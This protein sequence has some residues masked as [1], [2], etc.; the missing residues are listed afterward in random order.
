MR[1][2]PG[3]QCCRRRALHYFGGCF[4]YQKTHCKIK[5]EGWIGLEEILPEIQ[6]L[7]PKANFPSAPRRDARGG[8]MFGAEVK[9]CN[10]KE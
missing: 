2:V 6:N 9:G 7:K 5:L 8:F 4:A 10:M 1:R 3:V